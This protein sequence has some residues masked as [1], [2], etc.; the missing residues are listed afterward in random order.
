L[1]NPYPDKQITTKLQG[2]T[3]I[4]DTSLPKDTN[5]WE[6]GIK[7]TNFD[8]GEWVIIEQYEDENEAQRG[9]DKWVGLMKSTPD[10]PLK[11]IDSW[12]LHSE[13]Q[14]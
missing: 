7:R 12:S 3:I 5:I 10:M 13:D 9:H 2:N 4:I 8:D 6:T 11:D 14:N 1:D